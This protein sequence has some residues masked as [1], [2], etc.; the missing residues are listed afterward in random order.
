MPHMPPIQHNNL[1]VLMVLI[2]ILQNNPVHLKGPSIAS[3]I[4]EALN[5]HQHN[6]QYLKFTS[7]KMF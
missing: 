5:L 4:P 1:V 3:H 7:L 6:C 2:T